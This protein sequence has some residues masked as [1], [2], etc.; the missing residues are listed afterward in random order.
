MMSDEH[1]ILG[2][3][4]LLDGQLI[5]DTVFLSTQTN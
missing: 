3:A 5:A 4:L 2:I 1:C